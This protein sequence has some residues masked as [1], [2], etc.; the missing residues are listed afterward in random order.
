MFLRR[1]GGIGWATHKTWPQ[2]ER[3][4]SGR[5][6]SSPGRRPLWSVVLRTVPFVVV[7]LFFFLLC[8]SWVL[9]SHSKPFAPW[10]LLTSRAWPHE[11]TGSRRG[12]LNKLYLNSWLLVRF[13][14][15]T[16]AR[17]PPGTSVLRPLLLCAVLLPS[18]PE[19]AKN[20]MGVGAR[21]DVSS[22]SQLSEKA[23]GGRPW[24]GPRT[25]PH[26]PSRSRGN[27]FVPVKE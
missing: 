17:S 15:F 27:K 18:S 2:R 19:A 8:A 1:G 5:A 22:L 9:I 21:W 20:I 12:L 16:S 14:Y 7:L 26:P 4:P 24:L 11:A 25:N 13:F 6:S 3:S 23:K 10:R